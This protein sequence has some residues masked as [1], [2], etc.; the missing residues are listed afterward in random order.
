MEPSP[1]GLG[2]YQIMIYI[3][4]HKKKRN[5]LIT[6]FIASTIFL[7]VLLYTAY[8]YYA[9]PPSINVATST[10]DGTAVSNSLTPPSTVSQVANQTSVPQP[11]LPVRLIIPSIHV[12]A[13]VE[14]LGLAPDKSVDVPKGP[15]DVAWFDLGPRPGEQG[16]A[17]I[18][19]HFGPWLN[20]AHSVFDNLNQ[21]KPG[22]SIM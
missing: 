20:G 14:Q 10:N 9:V 11:A 13:A 17:V 4:N 16:S 8:Q 1:C 22:D 3:Q 6:I 21:V 2:S 19:G 12:D 5:L 15:Y 18:S 7:V